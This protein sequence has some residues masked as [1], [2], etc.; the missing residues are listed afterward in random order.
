MS[1][2]DDI[3]LRRLD[4]SLL[5]IFLG[6]MRHRKAARV[7]EEM[8]LTQSTISHALARLRDVFGD[9]LFLRR[10]H[11]LEPTARAEAMEPAVRAAVEALNGVLG[12]AAPF[13]PSASHATLRL[14]ALD[15]E[16][17]VLMPGFLARVASEAPGLR[18]SM[19]ALGR[20]AALAALEEGRVDLILGFVWDA[21]DRVLAEPLLE[22][23]YLLAARVDHPLLSQP[24][25]LEAYLAA[26][27]LVV[28][29]EGEMT[30]IVDRVLGREG[31][32]RQVAASVPQFLSALPVLA[33]TDLVATLPA[34]LV[35][36]HGAAFGLGWAEPP[37]TLRRFTTAAVRHRRDE[38][39]GLLLWAIDALQRAADTARPAS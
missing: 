2:F 15:Y 26:R 32:S 36:A 7:A 25:D 33:G 17:A 30:G 3:K 37:V 34:R 38:K 27:H 16:T 6:L 22:E 19:Q 18:V 35:K 29:P 31:V 14:S 10:P 9:P 1:E 8:R 5:L 39:N 28:A 11:G 20:E 23:G 24:G 13:D 21:P 4:L 12:S